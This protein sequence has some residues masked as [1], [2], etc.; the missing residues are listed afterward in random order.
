MSN[1]TGILRL[2]VENKK[3]KSVPKDVYF[4]GAF[5][6]MRP[7]Y[8]DN[9]GQ[10]CYFLINPGGGYVDG[11]TYRMEI[12]VEEEAELLLTTQSATKVYRTPNKPVVQETELTLKKNSLLEYI[13]DPLIGYHDASYKQKNVIRMERGSTLI[14][15]DMLTPGWSPEGELFSYDRLQLINEIY[16]EDELV[17]FDH[18]KLEPAKQNIESMGMMEGFTH[19]GS[20]IVI[21]EKLDSAFLDQLCDLLDK[22]SS[23]SKIGLSQLSVPGFTIRVLASTTQAI[24][25]I[26]MECHQFIREEWFGKKAVF[27]RKY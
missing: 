16:V 4:Q 3:G 2:T 12:T 24:E 23:N 15:S 10:V 18:L 5:K 21:G 11:D 14:Y 22:T 8:L 26:F 13:P 25:K 9:T 7:I 1:W 6:V 17:V 20:M 27:L 19:L